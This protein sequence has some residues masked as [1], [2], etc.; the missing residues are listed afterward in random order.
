MSASPRRRND[1]DD[2]DDEAFIKA[3]GD[4]KPGSITKIRLTNFMTHSNAEILP[5][6][7]YVI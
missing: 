7:R 3:I 4:F 2:S 6:S 1:F 5:G